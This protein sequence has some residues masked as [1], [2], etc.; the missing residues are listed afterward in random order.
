MEQSRLKS[1]E[2]RR[3]IGDLVFIYKLVY[4]HLGLDYS[5]VFL[6]HPMNKR[7]RGNGL[8]IALSTARTNFRKFSVTYRG[9]KLCNSL[10]PEAVI[11]LSVDMFKQ[12]LERTQFSFRF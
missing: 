7:L 5:E 1:L 6:L 4:G 10:P 12:Y 3:K 8:K 11:L 9:A 2:N